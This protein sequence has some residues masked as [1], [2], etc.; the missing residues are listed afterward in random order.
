MMKKHTKILLSILSI[1]LLLSACTEPEEFDN[2]L[3]GSW[4]Y[5]DYQT[6]DWEKIIFQE[7]LDY[8]LENYSASLIQTVTVT[9]T[10]AYTDTT[11]TFERRHYPD[12]VFK[13]VVSGNN[14]YVYLGKTY[15]RQ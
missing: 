6:D 14:L 7:N 3:I 15:I 2:V 1:L 4:K 8:R 11:Y 5:I 10:Y 12:I 13:Y 9:G